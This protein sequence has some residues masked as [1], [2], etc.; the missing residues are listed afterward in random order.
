MAFGEK[1]G[2]FDN[3]PIIHAVSREQSLATLERAAK[4]G[5]VHTVSNNQR[6]IYYIC[7]CC[8]CS[9]G[10]LRGMASLG[11]ANVIARSAF[12]NTVD[13]MLCNG[14]ET[15]VDF[16]QF[17]ALK[18][19]DVL[20]IEALRCVGCGVC[21]AACPS[22]ALALVRRPEEEILPIPDTLADWKTQRASFRGLTA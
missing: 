13:D 16:C 22:E 9:C 21:V 6:G 1:P 4:A 11:M 8:T 3:N 2:A 20:K 5:L 14:C 10:I 18:V 12:V 7:N 15:C 17:D 19:E